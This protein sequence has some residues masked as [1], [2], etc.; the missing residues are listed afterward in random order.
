VTTQ[1]TLPPSNRT[2]GKPAPAADA[3]LLT[4]ALTAMSATSFC[5]P[6]ADATGVKDA[7]N[8]SAAVAAGN[9]AVLGPGTYYL[10]VTVGPLVTGQWVICTPGV[11]INWL[12]TGDCFRWVDAST[13][14]ARTLTGGGLLG[15]PVIDGTSAGAGSTGLHFGD[16]LGFQFDVNV[17]NFASTGDI[18]IHPDNQNYW[19][20]QA[21]GR[22][23]ISNCT[24]DVVF[25]CGGADTS[26]G[27]FDRGD[28]AFYVQ[29][30]TFTGGVVTWQ[31]GA[32]QVGGWFRLYGNINSSATTFTQAVLTL[33]GQAP[34]G[35][36]SSFSGLQCGIDINVESDEGLAH[37]FQTINFGSTS[38][39]ITDSFGSINFGSGNLF[40]AS[41]ITSLSSQFTFFGP[42][43]GD[44]SLTE[45]TVPDRMAVNGAAFFHSSV[46][47]LLAASVSYTPADPA[48]NATGTLLMAGLGATCVFTPG[49][50]GKVQV[51]C[52]GV[53]LNNAGDG[54]F[55]RGSYGTGTAPANG[56]ALAGT[57]WGTGADSQ[58]QVKGAS[59]S[60][61]IPFS[62]TQVLSLTAGTAYWFDV[63]VAENGGGTS[64]VTNVV[65]SMTEL[66]A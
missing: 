47:T 63:A 42:V 13:Y 64:Q 32:Y 20:E 62:M 22:A 11:L 41:N 25:D 6:T 56:A 33:T 34:A 36:P 59:A 26:A 39:T 15:R 40:T 10:S 27:S 19:T 38:N 9:I 53:I 43:I 17:Q 52:T 5:M 21:I 57:K 4:T 51:T 31:N 14:T 61:G 2:T 60:S 1:V 18:A 58:L 35:H 49:L 30:K 23:Y 65:Y 37:T 24:S 8:I 66:L 12:G 28:F 55:L 54:S 46:S 48:G 50:T 3:D 7:A 29:H 16:I 45:V 44:S